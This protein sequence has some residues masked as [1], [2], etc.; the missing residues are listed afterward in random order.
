[1][2][3]LVISRVTGEGC[4]DY[5]ELQLKW[6]HLLLAALSPS[7]PRTPKMVELD[8]CLVDRGTF[9]YLGLVDGLGRPAC[10]G[11][12][13]FH[14]ILAGWVAEIH[15][16]VT[17]PEFRGKGYAREIMGT[18]LGKAASF[19]REHN[20]PKITVKLTSKPARQEANALYLQLGFSLIGQATEGGTNLYSLDVL[21]R[22]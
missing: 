18:L 16:I 9:I 1:M 13:I 6:I 17:L 21:A 15:D 10:M 7:N 2:S 22:E 20:L 4:S 5:R 3:K 8:A 12:I 14:R 19:A 11:T